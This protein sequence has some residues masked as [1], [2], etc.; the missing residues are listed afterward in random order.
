[1]KP[2]IFL[3]V[4]FLLAPLSA[5]A[6]GQPSRAWWLDS[7]VL[8]DCQ[9]GS[10][11]VVMHDGQCFLLLSD[12]VLKSI[13]GYSANAVSRRN[14][15][16]NASVDLNVDGNQ[17]F[18]ATAVYSSDE[19]KGRALLVASDPEF[20]ELKRIFREEGTRGFSALLVTEDEVRWYLCMDCG[21]YYTVVGSASGFFLQ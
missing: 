1:M 14:F 9:E 20:R 5:C 11:S 12:R 16:L 7:E 3:A 13:D 15:V 10:A 21:D 4:L 2:H 6:D 18:L 8:I 17:E 19:A